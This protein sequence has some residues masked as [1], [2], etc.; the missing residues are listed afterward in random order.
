[1]LFVHL[2]KRVVST[3]SANKEL[4]HNETLEVHNYVNL[5]WQIE[6]AYLNSILSTNLLLMVVT[7]N[8]NIFRNFIS[9][10]TL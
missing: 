8:M 6:Q 1:M 10:Q 2:D 7:C 3:W 5:N 9:R 4:I